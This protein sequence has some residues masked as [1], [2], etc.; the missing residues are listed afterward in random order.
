MIVHK[1]ISEL[2][3]IPSEGE[4][5][6]IVP[7]NFKGREKIEETLEHVRKESFPS[8][9]SRLTG[10]FVMP[11]M[12][13]IQDLAYEY[14]R[15]YVPNPNGMPK[16][17]YLLDIETAE[18]VSWH[19]H[20]VYDKICL[21]LRSQNIADNESLVKKYWESVNPK[22][23]KYTE[24]LIT[25]GTIVEVHRCQVDHHELSVLS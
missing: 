3:R 19:D 16:I 24:G 9:I 17:V 7:A 22:D 12:D 4:D 5:L 25:E 10:T 1:I 18:K 6:R 2:D 14:A 20:D 15:K 13:N 11:H 21:N 23:C 8:E